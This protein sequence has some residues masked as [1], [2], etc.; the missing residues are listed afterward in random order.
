MA[1]LRIGDVLEP[2]DDRL[3]NHDEPE[4][5]TLTEGRGFMP[6][7]QRF[8]KRLATEDT[9]DYKVVRRYDVAFNP[10]L[11]W[12][13]AIAQNQNWDMAII[14]PA[15]PTFHVRNG[16]DPRFV[17]HR[18]S[19]ESLRARFDSISFGAVPRRRRAATE[20]FLQ[21][22]FGDAPSLTE[23]RRVATILDQADALLAK[24]REA[25]VQLDSLAQSTFLEMFG[26]PV[27]SGWPTMSVEAV[28]DDSAGAIRTGPFG[29]QLLHSEFVDDG[30]AVL[31][32]DNAV[33]NEFR[34]GQ[35]RF[36]TEEK[37]RTLRRYTVKPGDVLITIMGTCGRCAVVP[38]DIPLA[39]NT[40]HL[41]CITLDKTKCLPTF[42]HS[43]FLWHPI[44]RQYL[45]QKSKGAIMNG[46]NMGII[47]SM[48]I[49]VP[50]V[51]LQEEFADRLAAI[52]QCKVAHVSAIALAEALITSVQH[53]AFRGEL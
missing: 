19:S 49:V 45:S 1:K 47:K 8:N 28:T 39:I 26:G 52:N 17:N 43:Y 20:E 51:S 34:W 27:N 36:I 24:R 3:G 11:L 21:L 15:Y 37:F 7:S 6:Q 22:E 25:L 41:C 33:A 38:D 16:F 10:Y 42:L 53:R 2:F 18:L 50:S 13:G 32:I 31:G 29:S 23:Q 35:R 14:S 12:A 9:S 5:L 30:I 40:K 48:P 46:L 4:I 44:A